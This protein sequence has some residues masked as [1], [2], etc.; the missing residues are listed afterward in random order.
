MA[1]LTIL[2]LV[3]LFGWGQYFFA[4]AKNSHKI[5][6]FQTAMAGTIASLGVYITASQ[7]NRIATRRFTFDI[8]NGRFSNTSYLTSSKTIIWALREAR[9]TNLGEIKSVIPN[10]SDKSTLYDAVVEYLNF[11]ELL[12]TAYVHGR[13]DREVF[14][15]SVDDMY[16]NIVRG[17]GRIIGEMRA[18]D[19]SAMEHICAV[20]FVLAKEDEKREYIPLL[21]P[22]PPQA[23]APVD[24]ALW[25]SAAAPP[26]D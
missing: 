22:K 6:Y 16:S 26:T 14:E 13:L 21:G 19:D 11:W 8:L 3:L 20:F 4:A 2:C 23:L 1:G 24:R 12:A 18:N 10:S 25:A 5:S 17:L 15:E 9:L 7:A